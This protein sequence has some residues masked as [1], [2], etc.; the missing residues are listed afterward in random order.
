MTDTPYRLHDSLGYKLSLAARLQEKR[1]EDHLKRHGLTRTTWCVLLAVGNEGLTQ[2]SDIATFIGID[3]TAISRALGQMET[4]GLIAREA[5]EADRRT[6][7][8]GLTARG[9]GLVATCTPYAVENNRILA[10]RLAEGSVDELRA[11]LARLI[12]GE[13]A[14][15]PRF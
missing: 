6:T 14:V 1:L 10:G 4:A 8:V 11:R 13:E 2:P 5:G 12:E 15:L 9:R 7:R 3:R